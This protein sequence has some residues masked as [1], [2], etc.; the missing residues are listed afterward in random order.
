MYRK[1]NKHYSTKLFNIKNIKSIFAI[2][3]FVLF[4]FNISFA[5]EIKMWDALDKLQNKIKRNS[6]IQIGGKAIIDDIYKLSLNQKQGDDMTPMF[7]ALSK[8]VNDINSKY[9][10]KMDTQE[11]INILYFANSTF[12]Q[13]L[14]NNL[15]DFEKPSRDNMWKSCNKLNVCIHKPK[16]WQLNNTPALNQSCQIKVEDT[17]LTFYLN[18]YYMHNIWWAIKWSN[19]F[20]NNSLDDSSY[21]IMNDIYMLGKILFQDVES[22]VKTLF[23]K[24]PDVNYNS[25]YQEPAMNMN[26]DWFSPYN[27]YSSP[28]GWINPNTNNVV[29]GAW[30]IVSTS[31]W[32]QQVVD[33]SIKDFVESV[34][35]NVTNPS[36][37][38]AGNQ[39]VSGFQVEEYNI[40]TTWDWQKEIL[41]PGQYLQSVLEDV[42][43]LSCNNDGVCQNW[44]TTTCPDCLSNG[45]P[46]FE[47]I[48][49][50]LQNAA[51][52]SND[53]ISQDD[54]VLGCFQKCQSLPCNAMNCD[55]LVCYAKCSCQVYESPIFDAMEYPGLSSAFKIKFCIIPVIDN[56]LS[57]NKF[58]YNIASIFME[59]HNVLQNLRN[60]GQLSTNVKTKEFLDSSKKENSFADQLSFSINSVT[61]PVSSNKS[62]LTQTQEQIEFNT[63]MMSSILWFSKDNNLDIEKNKYVLMDDPCVYKVA[64]QVSSNPSQRDNLIEACRQESKMDV[65]LPVDDMK[66]VIQNQQVILLNTEFDNFMQKNNE[67]WYQIYLMFGE[68]K[69]LSKTL[70]KK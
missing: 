69:E 29:S 22:P 1:Q 49:S 57:T 21:D 37:S 19:Y 38:F 64:K 18:S 6:E 4:F 7:D 35:L 36:L 25:I 48:Q 53:Q 59:I 32:V 12:K 42:S 33:D 11:V 56:K 58:V 13:D 5:F 65:S 63:N 55:K 9:S 10:C 2:L 27:N 70:S 30:V 23:F 61:K 60:S 41:T 50:L 46:D 26:I 31:T 52:Q 16:W 67:F 28:V 54:P 51:E 43:V 20:W 45:N 68:L 44:E 17:F 8:T 3:L 34:N 47:E 40:S 39:C 66:P 24:M 15:Q 62:E 14:K